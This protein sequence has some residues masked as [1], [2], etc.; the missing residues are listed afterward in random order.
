MNGDIEDA[1]SDTYTPTAATEGT[2]TATATYTDPRGAGAHGIWL[3]DESLWR[4]TPGTR[5]RCLVTRTTATEGTQNTE[6]DQD[7]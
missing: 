2:L 1:T 5:P 4:R 6:T 3:L 7:G